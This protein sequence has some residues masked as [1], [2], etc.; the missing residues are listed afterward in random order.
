MHN[1]IESIYVINQTEQLAD[2]IIVTDAATN[3]K[4]RAIH[5]IL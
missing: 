2:V 3:P 1:V 4:R 5:V